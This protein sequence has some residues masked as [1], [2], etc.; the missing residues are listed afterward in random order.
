MAIDKAFVVE[1]V[2]D[3]LVVVGKHRLVGFGLVLGI[4]SCEDPHN[5]MCLVCHAVDSPLDEFACML[6]L[7]TPD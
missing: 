5:M 6:V 7:S 1:L 3:M 2:V 4:V